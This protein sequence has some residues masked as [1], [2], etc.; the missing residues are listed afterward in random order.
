LQ[1][2]FYFIDKRI[3]KN[4]NILRKGAKARIFIE[5]QVP[6]RYIVIFL[7]RLFINFIKQFLAII[8][9]FRQSK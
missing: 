1:P 4:K 5:N 2:L 7:I 8:K 3:I 9:F 6:K